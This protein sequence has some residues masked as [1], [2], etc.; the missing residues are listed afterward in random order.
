MPDEQQT[1]IVPEAPS[2][3]TQVL[4][5]PLQYAIAAGTREA[6]AKGVSPNAVI[7]MQ[8]NQLCST[9]AL[10]QPPEVRVDAIQSVVAAI[11][12]LTREHVLRQNTTPG[13]IITPR[14]VQ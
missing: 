9:I 7:N 6:L 1:A 12:P 3:V 13:G 5:S 11:G 8:L 2:D 10:L 4:L 14:P